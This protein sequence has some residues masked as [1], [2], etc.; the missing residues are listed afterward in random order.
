MAKYTYLRIKLLGTEK[1]DMIV[2]N[3]P[4]INLWVLHRLHC[5]AGNLANIIVLITKRK[6]KNPNH[7][8]K[9]MTDTWKYLY[10]RKVLAGF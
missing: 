5:F 10:F 4:Y 3:D 8:H 1:T 6:D 2:P 7:K 9:E